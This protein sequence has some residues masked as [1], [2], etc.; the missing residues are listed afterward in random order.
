LFFNKTVGAVISAAKASYEATGG[1]NALAKV[2]GGLL[3]IVL[4]PLK[5]TF[6]S[7]K[8]GIQELQ[9]AWEKSFFGDKDPKTIKELNKNIK[10]TEKDI[11]DV[12]KKRCKIW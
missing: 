12:G 7:L 1:F 2:M 10:A 3:N 6:F 4:A 8:L 11:V 5:M 9:L